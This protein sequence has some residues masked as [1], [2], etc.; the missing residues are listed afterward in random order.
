MVKKVFIGDFDK[1]DLI[2]KT[3][4]DKLFIVGDDLDVDGDKI[5]YK[6]SICYKHYYR[7]LA[8][9]HGD[10][11]L[12]V[13]N[14]LKSTNRN[15]LEYNCIRH[16]CQ[17]SGNI[18]VFNDLPLLD[19]IKDF[20]ILYDFIQPNPFWKCELVDKYENVELNYKFDVR[21]DRLATTEA[22]KE[23]YEKLKIKTA[24]EVKTDTNII[25]RRL[26]K[27]AHSLKAD[28]YDLLTDF[29][30]KMNVCVS[31]LKV[32]QYFYNELQRKI[33]EAEA[34]YDCI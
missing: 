16:Y 20:L 24:T 21:V 12:V 11:L 2:K 10:S 8:S 27:Y 5:P 13:N 34:L 33:K 19:S 14:C 6:E 32:D 23:K 25:P 17:Q 30:Q 15:C 3:P 31:D 28:G 18:L 26:L 9:I 4:H 7:W 1:L 22:Q 29:K